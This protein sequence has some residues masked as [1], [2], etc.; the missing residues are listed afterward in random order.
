M[1]VW[2]SCGSFFGKDSG[3]KIIISETVNTGSEY[4][5]MKITWVHHFQIPKTVKLI[6]GISEQI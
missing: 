6:V 4:K 3:K 5:L 1:E 2:A